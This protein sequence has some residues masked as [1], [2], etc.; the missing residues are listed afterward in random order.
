MKKLSIVTPGVLA[1]LAF[2]FFVSIVP[3]HAAELTPAVSVDEIDL[4]GSG[5][6]EDGALNRKATARDL[7][8]LGEGTSK[9]IWESKP[10]L[11]KARHF[12]IAFKA[13]ISLGT[14]VSSYNGPN[15]IRAFQPVT[16][17][18]VSYLK[19]GAAAPGDVSKED[20]WV[21]LP[22]GA[23]KT[24][25]PGVKTRALR[26]SDVL[27][28]APFAP[29]SS[30][31]DR[32]LLFKERLYNALDLGHSSRGGTKGKPEILRLS[33]ND[34]Q[35]LSGVVILDQLRAPDAA[36]LKEE[37]KEN[38]LIAP[39]ADWAPIKW[40]VSTGVVVQRFSTA[41]KTRALR[42]T[43]AY[44][45]ENGTLQGVFPLTELGPTAQPPAEA[46]SPAPFTF[47]Y[48]M[49][50]SG[51]IAIDIKNQAGKPVRHLI[52][53]VGREKGPIAEPWDL[54]DNAGASVPP[55][56]YTWSAITRPPFKLTYENTVYNS[57]KPGWPAPVKGG[58]WWWADHTPPSTVCAVGDIVFIGSPVAESGHA[59]IAVDKHGDKLWGR[60]YISGGF[61]GPYRIVSDGRY[62][63]IVNSDIVLRVDP[64]ND[65][66]CE[67][68]YR[69]QFSRNLPDNGTNYGAFAGGAAIKD[70]K[71][72]V[73]Y[74]APPVSWLR[75]SFLPDAIDSDKSIPM[76][77]L[78]KGNGGRSQNDLNYRDD[79]YDELMKL[80]AT[81]LTEKTPKQTRTI[82]DSAL[83]SSRMASY[84]A[85]KDGPL[86]GTVTL[87]LKEPVAVGSVL[88]PDAKIKVYA[89]K[90]DV[91]VSK[92]ELGAEEV[93]DVDL[94]GGGNDLDSGIKPF[95]ED[96][97]IPLTSVAAAKPGSPAVAA[98]GPGGLMTRALRFKVAG[99]LRFALVT[100]RR[101]AD[102][103]GEAERVLNEGS[104][105]PGNG[106]NTLRTVDKPLNPLHPALMALTWKTPQSLRGVSFVDP[107]LGE[108]AVDT[109][110][111]SG[112]PKAA[113]GDDKQWRQI[114]HFDTPNFNGYFT[115]SPTSAS[116]DFGEAVSTRALR[117]RILRPFGGRFPNSGVF[118]PVVPPHHAG[119]AGIMA[120]APLGDDNP[121]LPAEL[122]ERVA[123]I[124]LPVTGTTATL[125]RQFP[126]KK[127]GQMALAPNGTIYSVSNG[128]I[129]S[130]PL[131][132]KTPKVLVKHGADQK[133]SAICFDPQGNLYAADC[134][135]ALI[136]RVWDKNGKPLRT[137]GTPGGTRLGAYDATRLDNPV[138]IGIDAAGKLWVIDNSYQPKRATQWSRT[139][140]LERV[141]MGVTQYGGGG[142]MDEGDRRV[143]NYQGMKFTID[144]T[145]KAWKLS[146]ILF[147][148]GLK[149]SI[150]GAMPDRPFYARGHRYLAGDT[151]R[152]DAIAT[153]CQ[154]INGVAVPRI[155]AGNLGQWKEVEH[156]PALAAKFSSLDLPSYAFIWVDKN[157]DGAPQP[158]EVQISERPKFASGAFFG[159]DLSLNFIGWKVKAK[160]ALLK[161]GAPD[162]DI[163]A[164]EERP[165]VQFPFWV[166]ADGRTFIR[167]DKM[168]A[169]DGKTVLWEYY[170][171]WNMHEGF[172]AAG[173]GYDRPAGELVQEHFV[174]GHL[175][176]KTPD[177]PEELFVNNS[178]G[179]D[180]P[181]FTRDGLL[182]G[183]IFGGP[184]GYGLKR[185]T[186]PHWEPGKVDLSDLRMF[187]EHYQG[188]VVKANDGRVYAIAGH[189]HISV[190]RVDGL[191]QMK[192]LKGTFKVTADDTRKAGEWVVARQTLD[193]ARLE[194]KVARLPYV[195]GPPN[196]DGGLND[197][198]DDAFLVIHD[199]WQRSSHLSKFITYAKGAM[200]YD[201]KNLYVAAWT[202][203]GNGMGNEGGDLKMLF[204]SGDAL[205]ILLGTNPKADPKRRNAGE[206]D[207][208][209][210]ISMV[211]GQPKAMLYRFRVA[212]S[213]GEKRVVFKS[214]V[215]E[216][217]VDDVEEI[218]GADIKIKP[219]NHKDGGGWDVEA[220]IPWAELGVPAPKVGER[221]RGDMGI[222]QSDQNRVKT[223]GRLYWAGKSQTVISDI[224]SEARV[225]P[226]VWGDLYTVEPE[227]AQKFGPEDNGLDLGP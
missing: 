152:S 31:L 182:V 29:A 87:V 90:A 105:T 32:F 26:F 211:K 144:W 137:I 86:A 163:K 4:A 146:D 30:K 51:F 18:F 220:A 106:W 45:T 50:R 132:G 184:T 43:S 60:G 179:G 135:P 94:G 219:A 195:E 201:D 186:V 37:S 5:V 165:G 141:F 112:D 222:L 46:D 100:A 187:Q 206:G 221:L 118:G 159:D 19:P 164:A 143:I 176:V 79:E 49:P 68:I 1:S 145:T 142:H 212:G 200:A 56:T 104:A 140:K 80:Y 67:E 28:D 15:T 14:V 63:Y 113:V 25:P 216:T 13:P 75:S 174:I 224:P 223:V 70:G 38:P 53:E 133:F 136:V 64:K 225:S 92:I 151:S 58:G 122:S 107:D 124:Q 114:G 21:R 2:A 99:S 189:N 160:G 153:L 127:P 181:V 203:D 20:Q 33:W 128:D 98:A 8:I 209:I 115:Q 183:C 110:T 131:D 190:V 16:G 57:G 61:T 84:D 81:F 175:T 101:F 35:P 120:L 111:G 205:D 55:G 130:M 6:F 123:E 210:L 213:S 162:Y 47:N 39:K 117:V 157:G 96:L 180:W 177:G 78:R 169:P 149:G 71:L 161:T 88:V 62:A 154:E 196:I 59:L 148:G 103:A 158:A 97:W 9:D 48:N 3:G 108:V 218:T 65:F 109:F 193:A 191:E 77:W 215:G 185:W 192:R 72:Y 134:G 217:T 91:P 168:L 11:K 208:R 204:K 12:R 34:A 197:W 155:A 139:G 171:K 27:T 23:V 178:D 93:G 116:A 226:S 74:S 40:P 42:L 173:Y 166:T 202:L 17:R 147:R 7:A 76:A 198:P 121:K 156:N 89:L 10:T 102:K 125:L 83:P 172:Y 188:N 129:V 95:D 138:S 52:A 69:F 207:L 214:P 150:Y 119:F 167:Y 194:Q 170:N 82:P 199:Y 73:S 24:L 36:L 227:T 66:K 44:W 126:F 85:V 54:K 41:V 22:A